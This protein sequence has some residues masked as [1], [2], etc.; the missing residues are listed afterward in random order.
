[1]LLPLSMLLQRC[2]HPCCSV[3]DPTITG[4]HA[5]AL[6][7]AVAGIHA[8]ASFSVVVLLLLL[9]LLAS[10]HHDVAAHVGKV[11]L[12]LETFTSEI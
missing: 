11:F 9:L 12:S 5:L 8:I 6:V 1:M 10:Q 3:V 4:V 7:N 2:R